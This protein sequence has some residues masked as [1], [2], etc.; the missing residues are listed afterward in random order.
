MHYVKNWIVSLATYTVFFGEIMFLI[1]YYCGAHFMEEPL[2][3]RIVDILYYVI[4]FTCFSVCSVYAIRVHELFERSTFYA[5]YQQGM[6]IKEWHNKSILQLFD[7]PYVSVSA[8]EDV[9]NPSAESLRERVREQ[10]ACVKQKATKRPLKEIMTSGKFAE[11]NEEP[12]F[13][14]RKAEGQKTLLTIKCV[15]TENGSTDEEEGIV[16]YIFNNVTALKMLEKN[17]AKE[18]FLDM[19]LATASHDI[20]TPLNI[21]LG[22]LD[23]L[24]DSVESAKGK[25]LIGISRNCGQRMLHYIKGL[26]FI[27]K[28]HLGE[29]AVEKTLLNPVDLVK[30]LLNNMEF[31]AHE[32]KLTFELAIDSKIPDTICSDKEMYSIVLLNLLENSLK[33]TF[34]GGVKV[35]LRHDPASAVLHTTVSDTGI[36]MTEEQRLSIGTLFKPSNRRSINPQGVGIGLFLAKTLTQKMGGELRLDSQCNR[37]S[38]AEFSV[39][40]Y[41]PEE[42]CAV[43]NHTSM[44]DTCPPTTMTQLPLTVECGC[45]KILL[46]DDEPLNLYVLSTYLDSIGLKADRAEN[47]KIALDLIAR[48]ALKDCCKGYNI[49]FMD[50]NMPVMDGVETTCKIRELVDKGQ[51]PSPCYIVAVTA[52]A[53]LDNPAVCADYME[54]G[55]T[56]L[57]MHPR[58]DQPYSAQ[59]GPQGGFP[60]CTQQVLLPVARNSAL[61]SL[62]TSRKQN[63]IAYTMN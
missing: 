48:R 28:F 58:V 43:R 30:S 3:G 8:K 21:I 2:G 57:C 50:I 60:S 49:V 63:A 12:L 26:S 61:S 39:V 22:V 35:R 47:G 56:D 23:S 46:V 29:L 11:L 36:G 20:R 33:Y 62:R 44:L 10:L 55:F 13:V 59:A 5:K 6:E 34:E 54:K 32:K 53:G 52:A 41:P 37:G 18:K 51:A 40:C 7:V 19:L 14:Y 42:A 38:T 24:D 17:K 25:E 31:S 9:E 16:E 1:M 15:Q 4:V 27:R 45:P